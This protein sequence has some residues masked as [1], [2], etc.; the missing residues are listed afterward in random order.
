MIDPWGT[1][2][3]PQGNKGKYIKQVEPFKEEINKFLKEMPE[4]TIKQGEEIDKPV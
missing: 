3:I 4:N 1:E 2:E